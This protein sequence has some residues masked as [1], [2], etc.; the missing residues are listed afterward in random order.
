MRMISCCS[1]RWVHMEGP[2]ANQC[3]PIRIQTEMNK[4]LTNY[5]GRNDNVTTVNY[6]LR[7]KLVTSLIHQ[8]K[9]LTLKWFW[10]YDRI[11]DRVID[12]LDPVYENVCFICVFVQKYNHNFMAIALDELINNCSLEL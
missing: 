7:M 8:L 11:L 1:V 3:K 4:V 10:K 9:G 2:E 12:L 6:C 5:L